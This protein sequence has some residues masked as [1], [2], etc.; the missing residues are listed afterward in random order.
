MWD[1]TRCSNCLPGDFDACHNLLSSVAVTTQPMPRE[2][3]A[4]TKLSSA[5]NHLGKSQPPNHLPIPEELPSINTVLSTNIP[6]LHHVPKALCD[7]WAR[8]I[9]S[10]LREVCESISVESGWVRL[11]MCCKCLLA[12]LAAGHCL[13]WRRILKLVRSCMAR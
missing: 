7:C 10:L 6:I 3:P 1:G 8:L 5:A 13:K 4:T 11:F 2:C 12:S 9:Q